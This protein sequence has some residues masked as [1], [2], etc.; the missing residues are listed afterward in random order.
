MYPAAFLKMRVVGNTS[1]LRM[2]ALRHCLP[3][4]N[5]R[6]PRQV[7]QQQHP[8]EDRRVHQQPHP[9]EHRRLHPQPHPQRWHPHLGSRLHRWRTCLYDTSEMDP[10]WEDARVIVIGKSIVLY[11]GSEMRCRLFAGCL[12]LFQLAGIVIH[13]TSSN[14]YVSNSDNDCEG[15]LKCMQRNDGESVYGCYWPEGDSNVDPNDDTDF[16]V[17]TSHLGF[18]LKLYWEPG[19]ATALAR[20]V[21][22]TPLLSYFVGAICF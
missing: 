20:Q 7:N 6:G 12:C 10:D 11:V 14:V 5:P 19:K 22:L 3:Q 8:P 1:R 18:N 13:A 17:D 9:R 15:S 4:P 21:S 2:F 16:C